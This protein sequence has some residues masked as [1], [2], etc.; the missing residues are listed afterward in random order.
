M[1]QIPSNTPTIIRWPE[2]EVRYTF[3]GPVASAYGDQQRVAAGATFDRCVWRG[4]NGPIESRLFRTTDAHQK[5]ATLVAVDTAQRK[6]YTWTWKRFNDDDLKTKKP[7]LQFDANGIPS[8]TWENLPVPRD[9]AFDLAADDD[10]VREQDCITIGMDLGK[11]AL[12]TTPGKVAAAVAAYKGLEWS[13]YA[14]SSI[15]RG[16]WSAGVAVVGT[17]IDWVFI[18]VVNTT[19]TVIAGTANVAV[20]NLGYPGI[21]IGGTVAAVSL[22]DTYLPQFQIIPRIQAQFNAIRELFPRN[23]AENRVL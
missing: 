6:V 9:M 2:T 8:I 11:T 16:G 7:M 19:Q 12:S 10:V 4:S 1:L 22:A 5:K 23:F 3:Q 13:C 17:A 20:E 21:A 18:P 14:A 15:A